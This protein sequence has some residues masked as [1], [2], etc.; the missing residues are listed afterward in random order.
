MNKAIVLGGTNDHVF[1]IQTLKNKGF[2]CILI[3]FLEN[4]PAKNYA[5]EFIQESTLNKE[6]VL[7]IA[8]QKQVKL[9]IATCIDQ[10]LVTS[11]YVSEKLGLPCHISYLTALNLTNK[12]LMKKMMW[13]NNIPTSKF[14]ILKNI[15]DVQLMD[16]FNYP[17]VI[18]P[19]DANS[20]KGVYKIESSKEID[21][22]YNLSKIHSVS[23]EVIIEEFVEGVELSVDV[24]IKNKKSTIL[25]VTEN[26]KSKENFNSFTITESIYKK[27]IEVKISSALEE[28]AD[29]IVSSFNIKNGPL[30]IQ[31]IYNKNNNTIN[32]IEFSS[33]IGGGSKHFYIKQVKGFDIL[34]NFV[35]VVLL[36]N[37]E[38]YNLH[39]K[40]NEAK[41]RYLYVKEGEIGQYINFESLKQE[42]VISEYFIYKEVGSYVKESL[43]ST[44]RCAGI[45]IVGSD[46]EELKSKEQK[47]RDKLQVINKNKENILIFI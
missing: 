19:V 26:V 25:M 15:N 10:A 20:S 40:T 34:S 4:P 7:D 12:K 24:F 46:E 32:V 29:K 39:F 6:A 9:V 36:N 27:D 5:D 47:C 45:F 22:Y 17:L 16:N 37:T 21:K 28:I 1:L 18:K 31:C 35:D 13:E 8:K 43:K 30:L 44:D 42:G 11:S 2:Y 3:D 14:K 38:E 41:F 23:G 33:R